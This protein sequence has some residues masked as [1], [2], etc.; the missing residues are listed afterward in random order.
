MPNAK[1]KVEI[2]DEDELNSY[3]KNSIEFLFDANRSK[4]IS[5]CSKSSQWW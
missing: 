2:K 4:T 3:G 5:A 1:I